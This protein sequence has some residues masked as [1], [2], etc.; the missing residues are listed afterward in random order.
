LIV[1]FFLS[2]L[3]L[4][5]QKIDVSYVADSTFYLLDTVKYSFPRQGS[6]SLFLLSDIRAQIAQLRKESY[7]AANVDSVVF[8]SD[9]AAVAYLYIGKQLVYGKLNWEGVDASYL[10]DARLRGISFDKEVVPAQIQFA[11]E[12]IRDQLDGKGYPLSQIYFE[13]EF[14]RN[15]SF[16]ADIKV[17]KGPL[18]KISK[19]ELVTDSLISAKF[20]KRFLDVK[21][22]DVFDLEKVRSI[23][24]PNVDNPDRLTISGEVT[25][26]L[27]NK[28]K[29][30]EEIYFY[31]RQL[32]PETQRI[33]MKVSYPYFL[34]LPFGVHGQFNLYRNGQESR[35][36]NAEGGIQYRASAF[37]TNI[38]LVSYQS[39][40]LINIDST[41]I[42]N[43]GALPASL[44]I[45]LNNI[46]YRYS[47]DKRD[48][49]FNP[50]KGLLT[51]V[52]LTA[53]IKSILKNNRI[54]DLRGEN[55]NFEN[56]Y[57]TLDLRVFQLSS[58]IEL[59]YFIPVGK[60][61]TVMM[62]N[63][64]GGKYNPTTV[65]SNEYYR[66]GGS[67]VLRG[68][69]EESIRAQYYSLFTAEFRY[70]LSLNSYFSAFIDYGFTYNEFRPTG[71][72]DDPLGFGVGL[73]F[74]TAAGI[75]GIDVALGREQNN[76]LDFRNTKTHFFISFVYIARCYKNGK[77]LNCRSTTS[78]KQNC[79][80]YE[81]CP[82]FALHYILLFTILTL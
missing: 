22:D 17:D 78:K 46:G 74:Q 4:Q 52:N 81:T 21:T 36:L 48:Y 6:D 23:P 72:W 24:L 28:L 40:R 5:A 73:S 43:A 59:A 35:D 16:Y 61:A 53:G 63:K 71:R 57:D 82:T 12:V 2:F 42:V 80:N 44:D 19:L 65:F 13:N 15:D 75:F 62:G 54:T 8:V 30:G 69:D 38:F 37:A 45:A 20:V 7:L 77:F 18:I 79:I 58:E 56:A 27:K 67:N 3:G 60:A 29:Q 32:K 39:S 66:I 49:R 31:F 26:D 51:N 34:N 25:A 9:S 10:Q 14:V 1:V 55:V 47:L 50:R 68:F 76:A 64:S 11:K 33:E 41:A 70:L